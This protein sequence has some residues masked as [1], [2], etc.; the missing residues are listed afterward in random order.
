M[1]VFEESVLKLSEVSTMRVNPLYTFP[2][3]KHFITH[4]MDLK[5]G[6]EKGLSSKHKMKTLVMC[7]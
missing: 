4:I 3:S 2:L 1:M 6:D 7:C 5:G